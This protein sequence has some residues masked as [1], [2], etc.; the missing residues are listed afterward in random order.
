MH[1]TRP[2]KPVHRPRAFIPVILGCLLAACATDAPGASDPSLAPIGSERPTRTDAPAD[3]VDPSSPAA[4]VGEVPADILA[5]ILADA[6]SETDLDPSEILVVRAESVTWPDGSLGCPEPGMMYT[7]A[8][9]DGYQ[10]VLD[11]DGE[12]LDYRV[13]ESG[14]FRICV[15]SGAPSGG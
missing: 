11:A 15:D 10:V 5:A 12:E 3:R 6:T 14:A 13:G 8:L 4:V 1:P 9:V 2:T 7:Q